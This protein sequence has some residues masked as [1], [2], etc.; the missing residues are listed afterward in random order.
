M[1]RRA[2]S[3]RSMTCASI[4]AWPTRSPR[5]HPGCCSLTPWLTLG[6]ADKFNVAM[7]RELAARGWEVTVATTLAGDNS[8]LPEFTRLTPDVF[9]TP[10][11]LH[12]TDVPGRSCGT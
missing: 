12:P 3:F 5:T 11:F 10:H 2:R 6:G 1:S 8:W 9:V 4:P 7:V